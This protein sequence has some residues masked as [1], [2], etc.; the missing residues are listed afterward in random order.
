MSAKTLAQ[1]QASVEQLDLAD[2]LRLLEY[3]TPRIAS[4]AVLASRP[5]SD[6]V[7]ADEAWR[8][9][10]AVGRRLTATSAPGAATLTDS[11]SQMRR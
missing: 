5:D 1:I 3:L 8:H 11:V 9:F 4:S 6:A 2:K 7:D 10:R